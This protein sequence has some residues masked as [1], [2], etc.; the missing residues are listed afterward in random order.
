MEDRGGPGADL[1]GVVESKF[2]GFLLE[3]ERAAEDVA[4]FG[5][6]E[7]QGNHFI[8][9]DGVS[10]AGLDFAL[11][12]AVKNAVSLGDDFVGAT[13]IPR[14]RNELGRLIGPGFEEKRGEG[15]KFGA[16]VPFPDGG[17]GGAAGDGFEGKPKGG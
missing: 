2:D 5:P 12:D 6:V 4:E 11:A 13:A 9:Q 15:F 8:G 3:T 14:A 10:V 16:E 17:E 7:F 1:E